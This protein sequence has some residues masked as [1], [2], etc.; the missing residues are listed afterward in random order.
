MAFVGAFDHGDAPPTHSWETESYLI[1]AEGW[2][3]L[4]SARYG[5]HA[6]ELHGTDIERMAA[7]AER[8]FQLAQYRAELAARRR[9]LAFREAIAHGMTRGL[10]V[11][12]S[13][14]LPQGFSK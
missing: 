12:S 8:D 3:A 9:A 14:C 13:G 10:L 6:P 7:C 1:D 2:Q 11:P 5:I 4:A